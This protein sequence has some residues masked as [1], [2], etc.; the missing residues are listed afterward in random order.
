MKTIHTII[1]LI[2]FSLLS[3]AQ[4]RST[5]PQGEQIPILIRCDDWGMSHSVNMAAKQV[6]EKG[7]P[8]SASVMFPCAWYQ[9]AVDLL[10]QFSNVSVGVHLTLNAEWKNYRWGPVA[11]RS[12]VPSLVDSNGYFFPSRE[13][14]FGNNPK[15]SEIEIE[16][17][18]QIER[19]IH[20]GVR[21]DYLDYHMGAAMQ[22]LETRAI[23]EKLAAEYHLAISRYFDEVDVENGYSVTPRNKLD[24]LLFNTK[25]LQ[26]G[27]TKLFVIHIG[28]DDPELSAMEDLNVFGPKDMS[29]H[30]QAEL[31]ALISP[32]FQSLIHSSKYRLVNY[33]KLIEEKGLNTMK[34]PEGL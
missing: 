26:P 30:R 33:R 5:T 12:V 28:I 20:S 23:V 7:F 3:T 25:K 19:A 8:V 9:E 22:T 11:G 29:K 21:I 2:L 27:G 31:N 17:R 13:K 32:Q 18:A 4:T 1:Y 16:L 34:R 24:T 10:K 15:L 14:L 6:L